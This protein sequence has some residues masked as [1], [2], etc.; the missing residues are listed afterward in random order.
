MVLATELFDTLHRVTALRFEA[1]GSTWTGI[2]IGSVLVS[3]PADGVLTFTESGTWRTEHGGEL[4][5]SNVF[6]WS[7]VG[8]ER[9]RLEHLRFGTDYPVELFEL[10]PTADGWRSVRLHLCEADCY[11][12]ELRLFPSG[13]WVAWQVSGPR[14]REAIE[15][16]YSLDERR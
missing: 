2:G 4:A 3:S 15:Y 13:V 11:A 9:V 14:K 8:P 10:E 7:I 12:A 16:T 1:R 5:F 6:R